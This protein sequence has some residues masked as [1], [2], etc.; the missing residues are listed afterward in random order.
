VTQL[1]TNPETARPLFTAEGVERAIIYVKRVLTD[2]VLASEDLVIARRKLE[3]IEMGLHVE[4]PHD[5]EP[6]YR[7]LVERLHELVE[8]IRLVGATIVDFEIGVV[9]FPTSTAKGDGVYLWSLRD[10]GPPALYKPEQVHEFFTKP[11]KPA[12]LK[13]G[14]D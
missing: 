8:E 12:S 7:R 1:V 14:L 5:A 9:T 13:G 2:V 11:A 10:G 4:D 6:E 3:R